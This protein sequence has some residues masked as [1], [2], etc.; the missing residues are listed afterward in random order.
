VDKELRQKIC[1]LIAGIVVSDDDL[2]ASE[3]A[4]LDRMLAKFEIPQSERDTIF[5]IVDREEAAAAIRAL[6]G[7][8]QKTVLSLLIEA[9][10]ADGKIAPE[11]RTYLKVVADEMG[12]EA[13]EVDRELQ[14]KLKA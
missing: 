7:D 13:A 10:A 12:V 5:P 6:P 8:L 1:R 14:L 3:E 2:E 4:F 11:E 9:A